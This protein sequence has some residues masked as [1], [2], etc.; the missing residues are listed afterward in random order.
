MIE[1][2]K[3]LQGMLFIFATFLGA[4]AQYMHIIIHA[5][6]HTLGIPCP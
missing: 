2:L 3:S 4:I 5:I 6:L 1:R